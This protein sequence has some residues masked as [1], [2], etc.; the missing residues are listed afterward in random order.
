L[1]ETFSDSHVAC[2]IL[3]SE[4]HV[5]MEKVKPLEDKLSESKNHLK[6]NLQ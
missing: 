1:I 4:N 3:K 2:N 6:K 5:L